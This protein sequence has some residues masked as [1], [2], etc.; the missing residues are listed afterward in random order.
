MGGADGSALAGARGERWLPVERLRSI[1]DAAGFV[2]DVGLALLFPAD[3]PIAPSLWEAVAGPDATPFAEGM[4]AAE[5]L[6]WTW[7]DQLPE[8]GYAWSGRFVHGRAS[9]L[10]PRLLAALYPGHGEPDDDRAFDLPPEA[11]QIA[12]A[13][14]GGPLPSSTLRGLVGHRGHYDRA[15][16]ELQRRLLVT[17]AGVRQQRSG[18][19]AVLLQLTSQR[20]EVG[21][22]DRRYA[23][24]RL[25]DTMV[26]TTPA[27]LARVYQWPTTAARAALDD[28]V[29]A[30]LAV[31]TP[32][33]YRT[34]AHPA[35]PPT[36]AA[37]SKQD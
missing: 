31:R 32:A 12:E 3:R 25:L 14:R 9:L 11:H 7:K 27:E 4:G 33:G 34:T 17:S 26:E 29:A 20:F 22:T 36:S 37:D 2:E 35:A 15:I 24:T 5:S 8:A 6:V 18:W 21:A 13:L 16:R 10:S 28:H 23:T 1:E 19:P 30:G